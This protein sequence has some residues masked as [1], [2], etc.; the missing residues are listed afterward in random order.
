MQWTVD[1]QVRVGIGV[2]TAAT[3]DRIASGQLKADLAGRLR[4]IAFHKDSLIA[5]NLFG[6][7]GTVPT[8]SDKNELVALQRKIAA[9]REPAPAFK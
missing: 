2:P 8:E 1:E 5:Q 3:L 7:R 4:F 6:W 9:L